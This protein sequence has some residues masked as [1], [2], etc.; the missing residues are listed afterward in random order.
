MIEELKKVCKTLENENLKNYNTYKL[1]C[2]ASYVVFPSNIDELTKILKILKEYNSKW[3]VLGNGSNVILPSHYDGVIIKL[4]NFNKCNIN[5]NEIY[6][7]SGYMLNKLAQELSNKGYTG[8]EWATGIP[9]TIGGSICGNAGAYKSS[10]S[11]IIKDVTILDNNDVITLSN[12]ELNFDYRDSILK[13]K[14][15]IVV[16]S[17][18]I[19][20]EKGNTEE[21]KKTIEERTL[22]RIE[23][24]PLDYPSCGS[25]FRNPEGLS[26]GKLIDDLGLKGYQIGGARIS[27]KHANFIINYNSATSEDIIK[28]IDLIKEKIKKNYNI[29]LVIEQEIIK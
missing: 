18:N 22:K 6:V 17:C 26:A 14:N 25:V 7:E 20:L 11:E 24:Q 12:K 29:D 4:S 5:G 23:T 2:S 27:E 21:I 8:I 9:G 19:K 13:H 10:M 1:D 28:L 15:G 16:L 3:F